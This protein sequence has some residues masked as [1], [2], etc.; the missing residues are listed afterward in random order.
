MRRAPRRSS[1]GIELAGGTAV[2]YHGGLPVLPIRWVLVRDPCRRFDPPAL[3]ATDPALTPVAIV[4]YFV[5]GWQVEVTIEEARRHLGLE[6]Q[7]QWSITGSRARP[8]CCSAL[9]PS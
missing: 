3:L 8:P 5:R 9:S 2:W 6:T 7:R 1:S 4:Q